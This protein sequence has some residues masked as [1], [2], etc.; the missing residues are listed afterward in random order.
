M[1]TTFIGRTGNQRVLEIAITNQTTTR[2]L[3]S[4]P[5]LNCRLCGSSDLHAAIDLGDQAFTGRF[6]KPDAP[7]E[8][9]G[10]LKIFQCSGCH[11]VQLSVRYD[12]TDF[13]GEEYGYRSGLNAGMV[14]H[15][16]SKVRDFEDRLE[17]GAGDVVL[18][19]GSND[20]ATTTNDHSRPLA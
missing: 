9:T 17:L 20:G 3:T 13:F 12:S 8:P 2:R 16:R 10:P 19:I 18:D 1:S 11:F 6:P 5:T 4:K 14:R 15:L 7:D